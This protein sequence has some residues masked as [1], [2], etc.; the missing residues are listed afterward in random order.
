MRSIDSKVIEDT[1][2]RLCIE[3][4][5]RLPPDVINAIEG[6]EKAGAVGRSR[7]HPLAAWR[8]CANSI[9]KNAARLPGYRHGL[10]V[11]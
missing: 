6:A 11:R 4:N 2:A 7:L 1:V 9:R 10:R 8:Q 5:L 3:A